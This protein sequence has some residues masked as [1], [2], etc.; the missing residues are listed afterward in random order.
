[1][2]KDFATYGELVG[3]V[4]VLLKSA[5]ANYEKIVDSIDWQSHEEKFV[6]DLD[7]DKKEFYLT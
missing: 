2:G 3:T 6:F 4:S 7:Y 1:M 5:F